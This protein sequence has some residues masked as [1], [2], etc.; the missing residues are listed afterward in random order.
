VAAFGGAAA[1]S[2]VTLF[3]V[4]DLWVGSI[5]VPTYAVVNGALAQTYV[6]QT[7]VD[8]GGLSGSRFG[9]RGSEDLG[10]GLKGNFLFE[11]GHDTSTGASAQGGLLFGR[12]A[13]VGLSGGFGEIRLGRQL[14]SYDDLKGGFTSAH[15]H[16]S[17][18]TTVGNGVLS[19]AELTAALS[20]AGPNV[21]QTAA[22]LNKLDGNLGAWVGYAPRF[23]NSIKYNS[24]N[25]GGVSAGFNVA[26]GEDKTANT[27]ATVNTAA[28]LVYANGPIG[29]GIGFQ[30]E[31]L[32]KTA[33]ATNKLT[34]TLFGGSYD[35][36]VA[37]LYAAFNQ[38]KYEIQNADATAK[39]FNIGVRAPVGPVTLVA[40]Y[41]RSKFEDSDPSTGFGAEAIYALSKRTDAYLGLASTKKDDET[42]NRLFAVGV[43]HRF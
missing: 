23:N 36:G 25:F 38:A 35:F 11:S 31:Q 13:Y 6:S 28:H 7:K 43:R 10:G 33:T 22:I 24:P 8:A 15:Q 17:F 5:K 9:L 39:E 1:Q 18:D 40:Q 26:L 21:T 29:I 14:T 30:Q 19:S 32:A 41:A 2:S 37:K 42:K 27:G 4:A 34:N 20:A 3:G 16:T 12:N